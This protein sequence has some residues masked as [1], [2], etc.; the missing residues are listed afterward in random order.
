VIAKFSIFKSLNLALQLKKIVYPQTGRLSL[1]LN[2][3]A[4]HADCPG[5]KI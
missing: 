1:A 2:G 3:D 4:K 5:W